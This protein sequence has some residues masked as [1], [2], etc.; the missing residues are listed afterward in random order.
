MSAG[1]VAEEEQSRVELTGRKT[2]HHTQLVNAGLD[3]CELCPPTMVFKQLHLRN[4]FANLH[5][6]SPLFAFSEKQQ[7]SAEQ[8]EVVKKEGDVVVEEPATSTRLRL[9][10]SSP[11]PGKHKTCLLFLLHLPSP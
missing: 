2:P 9:V 4:P 3:C 10:A 1:E 6:S 11:L 5:D 7:V 8:V